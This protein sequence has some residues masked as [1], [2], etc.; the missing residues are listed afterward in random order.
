MSRRRHPVWKPLLL[1]L[2]DVLAV[3]IG[4][5]LAYWIRFRAGW[6]DI[7]KGFDPEDY[8]RVLPWVWAFWIASLRFENLYRRRSRVFDFNAA[9]RILTGS[10][11][12][13]LMFF[14]FVFYVRTDARFSRVLIPIVFGSV[15]GCLLLE[16]AILARIVNGLITGRGFGLTRTAILGDGPMADRIYGH[17]G[18]TPNMA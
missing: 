7:S 12:A 9:R 16:R 14:A 10:V 11:L 1:M 3:G 2:T 4:L 13:L 17:S 6:F 8:M 5:V 18:A 15:S